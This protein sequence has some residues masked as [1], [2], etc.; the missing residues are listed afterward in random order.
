MLSLAAVHLGCTLAFVSSGANWTHDDYPSDNTEEI[1][2]V[3]QDTGQPNDLSGLGLEDLIEH[4]R[5]WVFVGIPGWGNFTLGEVMD[6]GSPGWSAF[7]D[8]GIPF[9]Q[10]HPVDVF[11]SIPNA[12]NRGI[13][14]ML[15]T[16]HCLG[17]FDNDGRVTGLDVPLFTQAYLAGDLS[18]DLNGNGIVEI[19]DQIAFMSLVGQGCVQVW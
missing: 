1:D 9:E 8:F 3:G 2:I 4:Y 19:F 6:M 13:V 15:P 12:R 14:L 5:N 7:E 18:A 10:Y 11:A 16:D 17:D